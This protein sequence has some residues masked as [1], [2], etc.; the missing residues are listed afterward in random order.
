MK[1][2]LKSKGFLVT[3]LSVSCIAILAACWLVGRDTKTA[4][5][6]DEQ[7]PDATQEEWK[8]TPETAGNS[9]REHTDAA[10]PGQNRA[11]EKLEDYP[12]VEEESEQEVVIDF[13][14][15]ETKDETPPPPPE[16]K[17][18]LADPGEDHPLNPAPETASS[19]TDNEK[20]TTPAAGS[21]N[22]NGAVYDPV[23]GWVVPG[24]VNQ[25]TVDSGGDPGKM[26]GNMGN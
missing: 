8:D 17:A 26:V 18:I 25:T 23:F 5:L 9:S 12:K 15:T 6:P 14:P 22:E 3:V 19:T 16:D 13:V 24:Q 11:E 7:P 10:V 1:K 20:D 4:F 2:I 21:T